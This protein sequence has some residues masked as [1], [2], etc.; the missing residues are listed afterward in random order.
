M[1]PLGSVA[2]LRPDLQAVAQKLIDVPPHEV[3]GEPAAVLGQLALL[4]ELVER[5]PRLLALRARCRAAV[6]QLAA[7][8]EDVRSA[9]ALTGEDDAALQR[10]L[11]VLDAHYRFGLE[12]GGANLKQCVISALE[13]ATDEYPTIAYG[14]RVLGAIASADE[15]RRSL[16]TASRLYQLSMRFWDRCGSGRDLRKTRA[17]LAADVLVPLGR[18]QDA[19]VEYDALIADPATTD[20]EVGWFHLLR[21]FAR[22][23]A[24]SWEGAEADFAAGERM[25][26]DPLNP[27]HLATAAW[28]RAVAAAR[29]GDKVAAIQHARR[30][31]SVATMVDDVLSVPC[32]CDL[33]MELGALGDLDL[34][35]HYLSRARERTDAYADRKSVV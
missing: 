28:G 26:R 31:E 27:M 4:G 24:G 5:E 25:A 19:A 10:W 15:S 11:T 30:A 9:L 8:W 22:A 34:A 14:L 12:G 3:P 1:N 32:L 16:E 29:R 20:D 33:S 6:G 2:E 21:G 13:G 35:E 18:F 23:D 17:G 7:A